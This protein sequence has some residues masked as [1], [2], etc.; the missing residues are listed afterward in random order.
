MFF[1]IETENSTEII[2]LSQISS[3]RQRNND[4][5]VELT[6]GRQISL[7]PNSAQELQNL[8]L[9]EQYNLKVQKSIQLPPGYFSI[10]IYPKSPVFNM[11]YTTQVASR[12]SDRLPVLIES[13]HW[14]TND[15]GDR[16]GGFNYLEK[17]MKMLS[18][19]N[20]PMVCKFLE[21]IQTESGIFYVSQ[22]LKGD[23]LFKFQ[24]RSNQ[25]IWLL[26]SQTLNILVDL[27]NSNSLPKA[28]L[29]LSVISNPLT[30]ELDFRPDSEN[31]EILVNLGYDF[32]EWLQWY[33]NKCD[34]QI[35]KRLIHW[36]Q[37]IN[38]SNLFRNIKDLETA[39]RKLQ[40]ITF[41]S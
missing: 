29:D 30:V 18:A 2:N 25:E 10:H 20:H 24:P 23:K 28:R 17:R 21:K 14:E 38:Q 8:L 36:L 35:D 1:T 37:A 19:I 3:F 11:G 27:K 9:K 39:Q 32:L 33:Q 7:M 15:F 40:H 12:K 41:K 31:E 6:N 22:W 4:T 16:S 26:L 13:Y 5:Q 34:F